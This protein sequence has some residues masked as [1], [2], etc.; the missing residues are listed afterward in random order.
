MAEQCSKELARA[1]NFQP[2]RV[3]TKGR[4]HRAS[5]ADVRMLGGLT[6]KVRGA[7]V[8]STLVSP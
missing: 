4:L 8:R 1:A 3:T 7:N 5:F 2:P 6:L